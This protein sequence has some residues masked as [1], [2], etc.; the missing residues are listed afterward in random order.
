MKTL[1]QHARAVLLAPTTDEH[2]FTVAQTLMQD[3]Q[4]LHSIRTYLEQHTSLHPN[5]M[6]VHL[7]MTAL[8]LHIRADALINTPSSNTPS[9]HAY[10][11][12]LQVTEDFV[13]TLSLCVVSAQAREVI[14]TRFHRF[15]QAFAYWQTLDRHVL[16]QQLAVA[17]VDI[18]CATAVME[19]SNTSKLYRELEQRASSIGATPHQLQGYVANHRASIIS[20]QAVREVSYI[21]NGV[22]VNG[23]NNFASTTQDNGH[24]DNIRNAHAFEQSVD[25]VVK[26]AFW[27]AFVARLDEKH[28]D[29]LTLLL[30]E[31]KHKLNALTPSRTD[32][33]QTIDRTI[34]TSLIVQMV[35]HDCLDANHF[36]KVTSFIVEHIQATQAPAHTS[37]TQD[38]YDQWHRRFLSGELSFARLCAQFL[39]RAHEDIDRTQETCQRICASNSRDVSK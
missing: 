32:I 3:A 35:Q 18:E 25:A 17:W 31:V 16:L 26:K 33:H 27:D 11:T 5:R 15:Q 21:V 9:H 34:D 12:L 8:V 14:A 28:T 4:S 7:T 23:L 39:A 1:L 13:E 38:W 19:L 30:N 10:L 29:Q 22:N 2:L 6:M 24:H 20:Q 37:A 36:L